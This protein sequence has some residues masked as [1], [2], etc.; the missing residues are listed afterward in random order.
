MT[1]T[2]ALKP[3]PK[4][5][6]RAELIKAGSRRFWVQCTQYGNGNCNAIGAQADNKKEAL[7][8]WNNKR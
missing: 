6:A 1:E 4:C 7:L 5:G 3:C 2:T 8:N